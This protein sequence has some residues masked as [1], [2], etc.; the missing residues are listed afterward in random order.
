MNSI[1]N[2]IKIVREKLRTYQIPKQIALNSHTL[3]LDT[4][5]FI[6]SHLATL[7]T[8]RDNYIVAL[9]YLERLEQLLKI[10]GNEDL[11]RA[12]GGNVK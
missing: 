5:S 12:M 7:S 10:V 11:V 2:R 3:L 1:E 8:Y 9:P 6:D 4:D